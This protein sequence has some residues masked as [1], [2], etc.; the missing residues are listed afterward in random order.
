MSSYVRV[1]I[2]NVLSTKCHKLLSRNLLSQRHCYYKVYT[3]WVLQKSVPDG[4]KPKECKFTKLHETPPV[5]Y[6]PTKDKVQE[7]VAKLRNLEIKTTIKKD[8]T[9]NFPVWH[10]NGTP[11]AS[12]CMWQ[13]YWM[14]SRSMVASMTTTRPMLEPSP[15]GMYVTYPYIG[16]HRDRVLL[17]HRYTW[18]LITTRYRM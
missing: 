18:Y 12:F 2:F 16:S 17:G 9:L 5:P 13:Q 8:T 11:E 15:R 7:E 14:Q 6:M 1:Q 4:F 3:W 10:K